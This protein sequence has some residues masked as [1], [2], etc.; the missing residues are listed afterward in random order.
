[1]AKAKKKN[2]KGKK[3]IAKSTKKRK[4]SKR[5]GKTVEMGRWNGHKFIV[6][7][8]LIRSFSDLQIKGSCE[9]KDK[10]NSKQGYVSRKGGNA[11]EVTLT[12]ILSAFTGCDVR[13]EAMAFVKEARAGKRDYFYVGGKKL[14]SSRLMLTAATVKNVEI[15]HS[16]TWV[17]AKVA[18]TMQQCGKNDNT[19]SSS[20]SSGSSSSGGGSG[21]SAKES[22]N[23][24]SPTTTTWPSNTF[25]GSTASAPKNTVLG[26]IKKV[27]G[28]FT[29]K[30]EK[31]S[32]AN[33]K[34]AKPRKANKI[35]T[36]T[37]TGG[38]G[39]RRYLSTR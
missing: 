28:I 26:G 22:V 34:I 25:S 29:K 24:S 12:I 5:A 8:T 6:S 10:K 31:G 7:P 19:D 1:M 11:T 39:G 30:S 16:K 38:G 23:S 18:L 37:M 9:L 2:T 27:T 15:S 17:N 21:G 35:Q 3:V 14:I 20:D 32:S 13:K 33:A 36:R 4:T